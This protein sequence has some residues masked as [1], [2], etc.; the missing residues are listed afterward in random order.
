MIKKLKL[1][2]LCSAIFFV[3]CSMTTSYTDAQDIFDATTITDATLD[4]KADAAYDICFTRETK[5]TNYLCLTE[6]ICSDNLGAIKIDQLKDECLQTICDWNKDSSGI[7]RCLPSSWQGA[8]LYGDINC[9]QPIALSSE[10]EAKYI[11]IAKM[12][13]AN[14]LMPESITV[15][16][17][18]GHYNN[19]DKYMLDQYSECVWTPIPICFSGFKFNC[20]MYYLG[21]IVN[22]TI[23]VEK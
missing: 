22:P 7:T 1:V 18:I 20:S 5:Q 9:T 10:K 15:Y 8:M 17:V 19:I 4:N 11:G 14:S 13:S 2:C 23:F 21:D 12:K 16:E 3:A 6:T